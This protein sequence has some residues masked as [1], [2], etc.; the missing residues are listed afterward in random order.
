MFCGECG[1]EN[2]NNEMYCKNCGRLI[3]ENNMQ[4]GNN[5]AQQEYNGQVQ[6]IEYS[7][8]ETIEHELY[9]YVNSNITEF[10]NAGNYVVRFVNV[11]DDIELDF[12]EIAVE[13]KQK[14][15]TINYAGYE[16]LV[17]DGEAKTITAELQGVCAGDVVTLTLE[18][19]TNINAGTYTVVSSI[20]NSNYKIK[21]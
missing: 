5:P 16:G 6:Q 15:L 13:I 11:P 4:M 14:E 12:S 21:R 7:L 2:N 9:T 8:S 20:D 3:Q 1:V 18:N 17:Y 10:K 19:A